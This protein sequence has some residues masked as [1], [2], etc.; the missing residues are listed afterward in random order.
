ML[1]SDANMQYS[2]LSAD[3]TTIRSATTAS[4]LALSIVL[5]AAFPFWMQRRE[6]AGKP[7]LIPNSLWRNIPFASTCVMV[8]LSYG[9]MNSM[10]LFSSL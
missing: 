10:E 1:V 9:M 2:I 5:L 6:K 4:L 7:A 3:L 8:M